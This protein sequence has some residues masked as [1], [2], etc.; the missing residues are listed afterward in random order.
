MNELNVKAVKFIDDPSSLATLRVMPNARV[1]GPKWGRDVQTIIKAAK[2]GQVRE[3]GNQVVV[4]EGTREWTLDRLDIT[5][6]YQGKAGAEVLCDKGILVALDKTVTPELREEGVANELNRVIQDLRKKAGYAVS[7][8]ILLLID[9]ELSPAWKEHLANLALA[10]L[11]AIAPS[12]VDTEAEETIEGRAF[13]I[14]I[15][16]KPDSHPVSVI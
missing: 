10:E 8:R 5:L 6:S 13:S 3:A 11:V 2:A 1:L 7:D 12:E 14:R 15:R 4:F 16:K 9:G